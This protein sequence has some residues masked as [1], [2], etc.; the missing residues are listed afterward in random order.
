MCCRHC[1]VTYCCVY[2]VLSE[3]S[4]YDFQCMAYASDRVHKSET[5]LVY[6]TEIEVVDYQLRVLFSIGDSTNMNSFDKI[7]LSSIKIP[8]KKIELTS[9]MITLQSI[10]MSFTINFLTHFL[11][12]INK[13]NSSINLTNPKI[14]F[15]NFSI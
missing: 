15:T 5:G 12:T 9:K 6:S 4:E 10:N 14:Y 1:C 13:H 11:S 8:N 7:K 3:Y 2:V